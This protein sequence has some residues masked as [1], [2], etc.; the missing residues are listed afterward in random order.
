M[1]NAHLYIESIKVD[2][3]IVTISIAIGTVFEG[4]D[5]KY[6]ILVIATDKP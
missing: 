6:Q 4:E 2:K 1:C 5:A 3:G